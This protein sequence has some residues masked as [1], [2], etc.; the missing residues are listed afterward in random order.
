M[1]SFVDVPAIRD[2]IPIAQT[3]G[4]ALSAPRVQRLSRMAS[5]V[6]TGAAL[7][8][9]AWELSILIPAVLTPGSH[10]LGLDFQIYQDRARDFVAGQGFY[11]P[12]QTAGPYAIS[13]TVSVSLY[14]PTLLY[15]LLPTLVLP[16][17][18]WWSPLI[19]LAFAIWRH[20][21]AGWA[22]FLIVLAFCWPRTWQAIVFG[23]PVIWGVGAIAA[24]TIWGWPFVGAFVKPVLA[25]LA[26]IGCRRRSWWLALLV[27]VLLSVP[28]GFLWV[29]YAHVLLNAHL[30]GMAPDYLW[31]ELPLAGVPIVAW[32]GRRRDRP[33]SLPP[34]G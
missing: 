16:P 9:A 29:D 28:L 24:G 3:L 25:P 33:L 18:V 8:F 4:R 15:A 6:A 27:A 13:P 22:L 21:P 11:L 5:M 19:V 14:P 31:G 26:L 2:R 7:L 30:E 23:N 12:M 32:L 17:V 20:R 34:A 10:S 1:T